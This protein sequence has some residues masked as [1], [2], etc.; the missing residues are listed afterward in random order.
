MKRSYKKYI[1]LGGLAALVVAFFVIKSLKVVENFRDKYEG[2]DL[3]GD[4][5]GL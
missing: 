4:V 5:G 1:L 3:T 2:Y